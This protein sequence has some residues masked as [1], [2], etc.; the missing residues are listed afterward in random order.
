[1][2]DIHKIKS[3]DGEVFSQIIDEYSGYLATVINS[4]CRLNIYDVEDIIAETMLALW[5]SAKNLDE[6]QSFKAYLATIARNKT[7][8]HLRKK[9]TEML[10]LDLNIPDDT[11]PENDFLRKEMS[12]FLNSKIEDLQEPDRTILH[13]KYYQGMKSK[14]IAEVLGLKPNAVDIRLSRQ[15]SKLKKLILQEG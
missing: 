2:P 7:I 1:M 11:S 10:E 3:G 8:D 4:V 9:R 13:L 5:K 15:R 6:E 12:E 14:E